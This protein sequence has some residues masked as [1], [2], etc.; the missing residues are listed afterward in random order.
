MDDFHQCEDLETFFDKT[1]EI[2]LGRK[3][4][5]IDSLDEHTQRKQWWK[6]SERLSA[7][8]WIVV[9]SCETL[10][11]I[12]M[13][14]VKNLTENIFLKQVSERIENLPI[15]IDSLVLTGHWNLAMRGWLS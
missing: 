3:V 4:L 1:K 7:E 13:N 5:L 2:S 8:G 11:G 15:G 10:I 12:T 9:W 14:S 6:I